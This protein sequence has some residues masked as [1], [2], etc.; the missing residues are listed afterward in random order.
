MKVTVTKNKYYN[1]I[2]FENSAGMTV[3]LT[4]LGAAIR[5]VKV[6]DKNGEVKTVTLCPTDDKIFV[7]GYHGKTIGRTS[8]RIN[9]ATFSI[10]G[11]TAVLEKNN[12]GRDNLHGGATGLH[13]QKFSYIIN[14]GE[15]YT[16][17]EFTYLSKDGEGGYFGNVKITV[18]Y[19][20]YEGQNRFG[21]IFKGVADEK[22]LLNLTNHVYWNMGGNLTEN[23]KEQTLFINASHV[24]KLNERLISEEVIAVPAEFDFRKPHKIGDFAEAENVQRHTTG[25][26]HP[27]FF[28]GSG[29]D[30]LACALQSEKSGIRL[31]VRTTYPCVVL[32][33]DNYADGNVEVYKDR[34]DEKYMAACLECQYHPDG[35]HQTPEK[36]GIISPENDYYEEVDYRFVIA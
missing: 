30:K 32:Y 10:D 25:Y 29:L 19:R 7:A 20:I 17:A 12:Y 35:V 3:C 15:K 14:E 2:T 11:K 4:D 21:I 31:E 34:L 18:I 24:G 36:C 27:F 16:E 5:E 9:G 22:T 6:P 13:A 33:T 28:A 23:V 1:L 26:D 8:G